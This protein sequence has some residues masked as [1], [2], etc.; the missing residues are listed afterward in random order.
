MLGRSRPGDR[1]AARAAAAAVLALAALPLCALETTLDWRVGEDLVTFRESILPQGSGFV[2]VITT[3]KGEYDRL[4]MDGRRS[5]VEWRREYE[6]EG[7]SVIATRRGAEVK[8]SGRY[9]GKPYERTYGFGDLPWYQFQELSY[10][11]LHGAEAK[12]ASFWTIDRSSLKSSLFTARRKQAT[13]IE[14]MGEKVRAVE[15]DLTVSGVP[16]LIFT[17]RFWLRESD[18]RFLRLDVPPVLTLPR[19]RVD[20]TS[21]SEKR[22]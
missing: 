19:S 10:E 16:A 17:S 3:N 14:I 21:E 20:L 18:G 7:T 1:R 11:Q 5:T 13:E 15:Y 8:V 22:R 2:A 4:V 6:S 9:K 12:T